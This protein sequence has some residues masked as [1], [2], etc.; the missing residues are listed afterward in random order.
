MSLS[1]D[2]VRTSLQG[3]YGDSIT[4]GDIRAWC[5]MNNGNYQTVTKKLDQYKIGRGK[6]NLEVTQEKVEQIE[7]II[8]HLLL[9]PLSS[10]ILS[11]KK[12]IPSSSLVILVILKKLF[13]PVYSIR[14]SLRVSLATAKRSRLSKRVLNWVENLSV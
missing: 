2:Y 13:S 9:F 12:M 5:A 3:L 6:W 14:R 7:K 10:K 4:S 8:R 1:S 11:H